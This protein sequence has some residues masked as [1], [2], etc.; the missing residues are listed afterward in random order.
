MR[1]ARPHAAE[2]PALRDLV[3]ERLLLLES[4]ARTLVRCAALIGY[5]LN[6][7]ML[8]TCAGATLD[9][10]IEAL[11]R[12]SEL[13]LVVAEPAGEYRFRH[14]LT[15]AAICDGLGE[16]QKR[17]LHAAIATALEH[18]P[19]AFVRTEQLAHHWWSAGDGIKAAAYGRL[20][21]EQA[22]RLG[23]DDDHGAEECRANC[24]G[25]EG[26]GWS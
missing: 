25:E 4:D 16:D 20:A 10:T 2:R 5:R 11:R 8:A 3:D 19:D 21:A 6:P 13:D 24:A 26:A 14:A 23:A 22:H 12:A 15:R 7:R 1:L 9:A 17:S 18:L